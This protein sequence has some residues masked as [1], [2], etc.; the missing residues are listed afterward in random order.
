MLLAF[1]LMGVVLIGSQYLLPPPPEPPAKIATSTK[2]IA[3]EVAQATAPAPVVSTARPSA[4]QVSAGNEQE[5]IVDTNLFK[6]VL[7]NR[8]AVVKSWVLKKHK[9]N[10]GK[11]QELVNTLGA[12]KAGYPLGI[13]IV[14]GGDATPINQALYRVNVSNGGLKVSF[15]Y[16][17]QTWHVTKVFEFDNNSYLGRISSDLMLGGQPK[18]HLLV[19]RGGFGD[20]T[21]VGAATTQ[22]AVHFNLDTQELVLRTAS[23]AK[24][25]PMKDI[26][27]Y[28]FGGIMDNYFA[29]VVLPDATAGFNVQTLMDTVGNPIEPAEV[30]T[31]GV[32]VG[33]ATS[34]RF[35][36]FVGPKDTD[37]LRTVNPKLVQLI[38]WAPSFIV[39][40]AW[41]SPIVKGLFLSL[42][43]F[44]D[45]Y[46]HNY[47][48]SI[49]VIT[50]L[51]N[52]LLIPLKVTS[53]KSMR[54]M[55]AI[56]PQIAAINEKYK[57]LSIK[58]P[59][60]SQQNEEVMA[61]YKKH[62]VNPAGGCVPM[63]LQIPFFIAYYKVLSTAIEM[64]GASWLW[65]GDLS[66]HDLLYILPIVMM[67]SQF[68]MQKM[69]PST[70]ADP[71]QQKMMMFMP[72]MFGVMF[73]KAPAG[74]VLYWLTGNLVGI[75]QQSIFNKIFPAPAPANVPAVKKPG[76]K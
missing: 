1:G 72:I 19:W 27:N 50:V 3:E 5:I 36:L 17:D 44:N 33:G 68:L 12:V 9:D 11:Q 14:D 37:L 46:A 56:Q 64:R 48:W 10:T 8:G 75:A 76:R 7:S 54:K 62:G 73:I 58:D 4:G 2:P 59:K 22:H 28:S 45:K 70:S 38:D 49:I 18:P 6:V 30:A 53:L 66:R 69:T 42:N 47:G 16:G 57:G 52:F 13:K 26:G 21:A 24:N 51:I 61:L 74:L 32:A 23:D 43:W 71:A 15:E 39:R 55:S 34:N 67:A 60:K 20:A 25:G 65:V 63:L 35:E 40:H 31:P 29:A 41:L